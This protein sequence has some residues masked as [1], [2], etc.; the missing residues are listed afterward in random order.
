MRVK[1]RVFRLVLFGW[2]TLALW[3]GIPWS[4]SAQDF[5]SKPITLYCGFAAG[6]TVDLVARS[7]ASGAEK[8]LGVPIVVET[9]AGGSSTVC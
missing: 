2:V 6:G 3:V 1:N 5:P 7:L 4:A 9:K 8:L